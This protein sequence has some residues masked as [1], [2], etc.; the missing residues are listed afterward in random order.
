MP[1]LCSWLVVL[2]LVPRVAAFQTLHRRPLRRGA[3]IAAVDKPI[4]AVDEALPG[5]YQRGLI[6]IGSITVVFAS[7]SPVLHAAATGAAAP[8]V[9]LLNACCAAP[10]RGPARR[11]PLLAP[12]APTRAAAAADAGRADEALALR[13]GVELGLWKFLGAT[14]NLYRLSLTSADHGAFLIQLTT[15]IVPLAQG[16]RGVPIPRRIW[17]AVAAALAGVLLFTRDPAAAAT[18]ASD[19]GDALCVLAAVFYATYDLRLFEWGKVV[20]PVDLITTKIATQAALSVS[21]ARR[22]R[23]LRRSSAPSPP[24]RRP[25]ASRCSRPPPRG[26]ASR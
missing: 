22:S 15:L 1:R 9:L 25:R 2:A 8:P 17:L 6:T 10:R 18:A 5:D 11:R 16:A 24:R 21:A 13:G 4:A 23:R 20:A 3:A 26:P 12:L 19:A 7:N 14:A